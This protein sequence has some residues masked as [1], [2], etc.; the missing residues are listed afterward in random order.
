MT[1]AFLTGTEEVLPL[2]G[3]WRFVNGTFY[4]LAATPAGEGGRHRPPPDKRR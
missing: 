3:Y 4:R 2:L 1:G